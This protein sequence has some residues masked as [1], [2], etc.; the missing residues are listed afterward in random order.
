VGT[1]V[2]DEGVD[3]SDIIRKAVEY[4]G[5]F[6]ADPNSAD[7]V[8]DLVELQASTLHELDDIVNIGDCLR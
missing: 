1:N 2:V 7:D 6:V 3:S 5:E 8:L 4:L